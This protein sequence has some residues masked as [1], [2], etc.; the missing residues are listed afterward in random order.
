MDRTSTCP[1]CGAPETGPGIFECGTTLSRKWYG[2]KRYKYHHDC[3]QNKACGDACM[4]LVLDCINRK[5]QSLNWPLQDV[6]HEG[7]RNFGDFVV[8]V[9][10]KAKR[11]KPSNE[12]KRARKRGEG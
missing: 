5:A 3:N 6:V 7:G 1:K 12:R 2:V 11:R 8:T 4:A 10:S 9:T